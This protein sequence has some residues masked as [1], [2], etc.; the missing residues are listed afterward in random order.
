M[1]IVTE[2]ASTQRTPVLPSTRPPSRAWCHP[3]N[4]RPSSPQGLCSPRLLSKLLE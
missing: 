3:P 1:L 4:V 2:A